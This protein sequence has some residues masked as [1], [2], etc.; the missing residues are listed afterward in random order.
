MKF[1]LCNTFKSFIFVGLGK[2]ID[3]STL[4]YFYIKIYRLST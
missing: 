3:N 2:F 1:F 4:I